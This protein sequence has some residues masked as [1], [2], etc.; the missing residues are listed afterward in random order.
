MAYNILIVIHVA[1]CV[2]LIL[3]VLIQGGRGAGLM[4]FG[5]GGDL[6]NTPSGTTFIK[7]FTGVVAGVFAL[8]SLFLTLLT[9]RSSMTSV[10]SRVPKQP[11]P[12]EAPAVPGGEQGSAAPAAP[13]D[14]TERPPAQ[15]ERRTSAPAPSDA[16]KTAPS[17]KS[18]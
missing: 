12:V 5:G 13:S 4:V 9:T 17:K 6:I 15:G 14:G 1:A 8:T 7:K 16:G 18:P 3:T 2:L 10:T 11:A